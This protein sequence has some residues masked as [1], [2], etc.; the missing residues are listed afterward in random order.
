[1]KLFDLNVYLPVQPS[2]KAIWFD[3]YKWMYGQYNDLMKQQYSNAFMFSNNLTTMC[4]TDIP[5]NMWKEYIRNR[6]QF[7]EASV[8]CTA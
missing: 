6:W 8:R 1:M 5:S 4:P 2:D 7:T 3:G